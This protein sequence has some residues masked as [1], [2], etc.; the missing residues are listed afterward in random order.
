MQTEKNNDNAQTE[1]ARVNVDTI[2]KA[3]SM[4]IKKIETI[5]KKKKKKDQDEVPTDDDEAS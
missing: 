3:T 4:S 2:E 5:I 1:N